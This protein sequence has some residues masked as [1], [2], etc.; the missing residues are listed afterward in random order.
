MPRMQVAFVDDGNSRPIEPRF[1][2]RA[3]QV[4]TRGCH[5][6]TLTNG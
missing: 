3:D 6:S 2:A 4:H 1:E 5:G